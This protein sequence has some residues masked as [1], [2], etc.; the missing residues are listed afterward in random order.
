MTFGSCLLLL[1]FATIIYIWI[2]LTPQNTIVIRLG[3]NPNRLPPIN[4][5]FMEFKTLVDNKAPLNDRSSTFKSPYTSPCCVNEM[6][7]NRQ[8]YNYVGL[9]LL[10]FWVFMTHCFV[11]EQLSP[12]LA[13]NG[14]YFQLQQMF[15]A[16]GLK[17]SIWSICFLSVFSVN[18][19]IFSSETVI[20]CKRTFLWLKISIAVAI[21][22]TS[23]F[24]LYGI[25]RFATR[26]RPEDQITPGYQF[27]NFF[28]VSTVCGLNYICIDKM[29]SLTFSIVFLGLISF[30]SLFVYDYIGDG[31]NCESLKKLVFAG[32]LICENVFFLVNPVLRLPC[33]CFNPALSDD[34]IYR[35]GNFFGYYFDNIDE[36]I[37]VTNKFIQGYSVFAML[38]GLICPSF[39]ATI[40]ILLDTNLRGRFLDF[41][42]FPNIFVRP[43]NHEGDRG[44]DEEQGRLIFDRHGHERREED[45]DRM[46]IDVSEVDLG[47]DYHDCAEEPVWNNDAQ[48]FP[49]DHTYNDCGDGG[50]GVEPHDIHQPPR[51]FHTPVYDPDSVYH[52]P[53]S[54]AR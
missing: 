9:A 39:N 16:E 44:V 34:E 53:H 1:F 5:T 35:C 23:F 12:N 41:C 38:F 26:N 20:W 15:V 45:D 43:E 7:S 13:T 28:L 17:I 3:V 24:V 49:N 4:E 25:F 19:T 51:D 52:A 47:E 18:E 8:T 2:W 54:A 42:Q 21:A 22:P 30:F 6:D 37:K 31:F 36:F 29:Q 40:F 33:S 46:S 27:I 32:L 48:G 14:C 11:F 50:N 10:A